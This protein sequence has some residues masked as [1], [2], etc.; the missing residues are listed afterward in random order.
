MSQRD[1]FGQSYDVSGSGT[2]SQGNHYCSRD[3]GSS[4]S[5][6]NAYHYSNQDGS[7][8]YSNSDG[9]MI[10][11]TFLAGLYSH[12][13]TTERESISAILS[14]FPR[15]IYQTA[16]KIQPDSPKIFTDSW[17][18]NNPQHYYKLFTDKSA[19]EFV[20]KLYTVRNP[21][22]VQVFREVRQRIIAADLLRYIVMFELG[23][24]YADV[25]SECLRAIDTWGVPQNGSINLVVGLETNEL[26]AETFTDEQVAEFG[27]VHRLQFLQWVLM[28]MPG[29]VVMKTAIDRVVDGVLDKAR[30]QQKP[31]DSLRFTHAEILNL[32]GPGL[33]THIV[34]A[35]IAE[36]E[37][38]QVP[39]SELASTSFD[40]FVADV[41]ILPVNAW[42][43]GQRHSQSG[44][45]DTALVY[46]SFAGSWK[47]SW[48]QDLWPW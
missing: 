5:N 35:H 36:M 27:F 13:R 17:K 46:H 10:A 15:A 40:H 6:S 23:G 11:I 38:R 7:Y 16:A 29:H 19:L 24:I 4:A 12:Y 39:D 22:I 21:N 3:Y 42:A 25:D 30:V 33:Y 8:H 9:S 1:N 20:E 28:A 41:M 31:I 47:K 45:V 32:S 48:W 44:P 18:R 26:D 34:K 14:N 37:H 2:N 43:P